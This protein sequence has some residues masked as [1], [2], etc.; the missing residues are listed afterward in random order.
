MS[1]RHSYRLVDLVSSGEGATDA[2]PLPTSLM[3]LVASMK[4]SD[5]C[6]ASHRWSTEQLLQQ[7]DDDRN[8]AARLSALRRK[9]TVVD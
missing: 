6:S 7:R 9:D 1:P 5:I 3:V 2:N 8:I 4:T